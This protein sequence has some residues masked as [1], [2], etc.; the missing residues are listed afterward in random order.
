MPPRTLSLKKKYP[1]AS[2]SKVAR[3]ASGPHLKSNRPCPCCLTSL[4]GS[5]GSICRYRRAGGLE[6]LFEC[7]R[8]PGFAPGTG[9]GT[10]RRERESR[11]IRCCRPAL[12]YAVA[13]T[14]RS[15]GEMISPTVTGLLLGLVMPSQSRSVGSPSYA[16]DAGGR[17]ALA[18]LGSRCTSDL[19]SDTSC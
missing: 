1:A 2:F 16:E 19:R 18:N 5:R 3:F 14:M 13:T 9:L 15:R 10:W 12:H 11:C 6:A 8:S 17:S 7:R 4:T